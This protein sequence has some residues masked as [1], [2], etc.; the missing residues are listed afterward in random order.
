MAVDIKQIMSYRENPQEWEESIKSSVF[1]PRLDQLLA[2]IEKLKSDYRLSGSQSQTMEDKWLHKIR[3][4]AKDDGWDF[5]G[6]SPEEAAAK[7]L[8]WILEQEREGRS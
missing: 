6:S 7:A 8:V 2:E 4:W 5:I 3:V 1:A